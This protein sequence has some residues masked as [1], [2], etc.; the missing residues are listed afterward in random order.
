MAVSYPENQQTASTKKA[1]QPPTSREDARPSIC[2]PDVWKAIYRAVAATDS[3][4]DITHK[5]IHLPGESIP[6]PSGHPIY[7]E[8][9]RVWLEK[10][11]IHILAC[12]SRPTT[13]N[14]KSGDKRHGPSPYRNTVPHWKATT[15]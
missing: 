5:L 6:F 8:A 14:T 13:D 4:A 15:P 11:R 12:D 2:T 7:K 9:E 3:V 10:Y 1:R